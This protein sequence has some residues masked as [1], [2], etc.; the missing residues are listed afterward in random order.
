MVALP[1]GQVMRAARVELVVAMHAV[2]LLNHATHL[3]SVW[4]CCCT[5]NVLGLLLLYQMIPHNP[6]PNRLSSLG[7]M[8]ALNA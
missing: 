1:S 7:C 6:L 2:L 5:R 3:V 8:A 4:T